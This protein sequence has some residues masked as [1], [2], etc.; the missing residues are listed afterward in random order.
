MRELHKAEND[1]KIKNNEIAKQMRND[2]KI[3][4][5]INKMLKML[6][7]KQNVYDDFCRIYHILQLFVSFGQ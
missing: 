4:S 5:L 1:K 3:K 6:Y 2:F 7:K